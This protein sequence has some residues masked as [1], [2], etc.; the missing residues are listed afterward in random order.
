[1]HSCWMKVLIYFTKR[2][3]TLFISDMA[4]LSLSHLWVCV[5][6]LH[7]LWTADIGNALPEYVKREREKKKQCVCVCVCVWES[8]S[9][10]E[11]VCVCIKERQS[12]Q[13]Q[14]QGQLDWMSVLSGKIKHIKV[15]H[16]LEICSSP[17]FPVIMWQYTINLPPSHSV[18]PLSLSGIHTSN[19]KN[20]YFAFKC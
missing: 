19:Y 11:R 1:M 5:S 9:E 3:C 20:I 12:R 7:L 13:R 4:W 15:Q 16:H 14:C 17:L 8:E 10:R 6:Y 18:I 2:Q